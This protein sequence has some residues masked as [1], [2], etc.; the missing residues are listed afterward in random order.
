MLVEG[1]KNEKQKTD[2]QRVATAKTQ[3]IVPKR[4]SYHYRSR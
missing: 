2:P 1:E 3:S 4:S